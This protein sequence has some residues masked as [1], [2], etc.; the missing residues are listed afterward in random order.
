M[1][2]PKGVKLVG[3]ET[4]FV[5]TDLEAKFDKLLELSGVTDYLKSETENGFE[6]ILG[7]E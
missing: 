5:P 4:Y 7:E 6:Y 2:L 3:E 1:K